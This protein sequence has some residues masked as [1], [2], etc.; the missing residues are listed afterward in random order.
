MDDSYSPG[1]GVKEC[2][3][4]HLT[5]PWDK[6]GRR[7]DQGV[8]RRRRHCLDCV[9]EQQRRRQHKSPDKMQKARDHTKSKQHE[10]RI[11]LTEYKV[12]AGCMDCGFSAHAAALDFDHRPG[13]EKFFMIMRDGLCRSW[14]AVW[15]EVAKCDVVCANCHRIR[16]WARRQEVSA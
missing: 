16:T 8:T 2:T 12:L 3:S 15:E 1:Y 7:S 9:S 10:R 4:C 13:E 6:F 11:A 5:L 14:V